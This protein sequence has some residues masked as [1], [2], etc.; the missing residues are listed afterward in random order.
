[1]VERFW[2]REL[3]LLWRCLSLSSRGSMVIGCLF[4]L[5]FCH[6]MRSWPPRLPKSSHKC[7]WRMTVLSLYLPMLQKWTKVFTGNMY[8]VI[9][10]LTL[11]AVL[12]CM[13][14]KRS[15]SLK[16][17][18][19]I[20][21]QSKIFK[22]YLMLPSRSSSSCCMDFFYEL[23]ASWVYLYY[24]NQISSPCECSII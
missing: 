5:I 1:M 15:T 23:S 17:L 7:L 3:H 20:K 22:I 2:I 10:H 13:G 18:S 11:W 4:Y 14:G 9:N 24:H 16:G 19:P 8:L 12:R 21:E 6:R